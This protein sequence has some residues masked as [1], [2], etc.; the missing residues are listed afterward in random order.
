MVNAVNATVSRNT[1]VRFRLRD[2]LI[3]TTLVCVAVGW[4]ARDSRL[5]SLEEQ[6]L[7]ELFGETSATRYAAGRIEF[8]AIQPSERPPEDLLAQLAC[9]RRLRDLCLLDAK[10]TNR[11][12]NGLP[13]VADLRRLY[14]RGSDLTSDQVPLLAS[15]RGLTLLDIGETQVGD[16]GLRSLQKLPKL[17]KLYLRG[18]RVTDAGMAHVA[19]IESLRWLALD[20]TTISDEG[21][22]RI[23]TLP[24]L[25]I[26]WLQHTN[27]T[28]RG[29][30]ALAGSPSLKQVEVDHTLVTSAGVSWLRRQRPDIAVINEKRGY[31]HDLAAL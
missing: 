11:F 21:V 31:V 8:L 22:E 18:A 9:L 29:L 12:L 23:A 2:L 17:E 7:S 5:A 30:R 4:V 6:A 14:L 25:E 16:D 15:L 27:T 10:L 19:A 20:E 26:L 3:A 28:D 24:S 1:R 13:R